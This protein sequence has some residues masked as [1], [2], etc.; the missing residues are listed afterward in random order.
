MKEVEPIPAAVI[1]MF[2]SSQRLG[3]AQKVIERVRSIGL[4]GP[5][6]ILKIEDFEEE[7]GKT[8]RIYLR[9]TEKQAEEVLSSLRRDIDRLWRLQQDLQLLNGGVQEIVKD[10]ILEGV[11]EW[12]E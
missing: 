5:Y 6:E 3:V 1:R 11:V 9:A 2:V 10:D 4:L 12:L 8:F 7:G